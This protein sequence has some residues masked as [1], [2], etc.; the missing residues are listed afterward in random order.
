ME[1]EDWSCDVDC[2]TVRLLEQTPTPTTGTTITITII[3]IS[4]IM[5]A[6]A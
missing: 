1:M 4:K 6:M 5:A 3:S 2:Q